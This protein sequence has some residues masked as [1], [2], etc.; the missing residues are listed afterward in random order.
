MCSYNAI[1]GT[2]SCAND[3]LLDAT[4]RKGWGFEGFVVG[5]ALLLRV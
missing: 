1:N 5:E 2:P 4:L 3:W